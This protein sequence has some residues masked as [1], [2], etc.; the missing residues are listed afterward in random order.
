MSVM[1]CVDLDIWTM[2]AGFTFFSKHMY[3][4]NCART[5]I[6][7][8]TRYHSYVP[9]NCCEDYCCYYYRAGRCDCTAPY[10]VRELYSCAEEAPGSYTVLFVVAHICFPAAY[11]S[12]YLL[13]AN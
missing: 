13:A 9:V 3:T 2:L 8:R 6:C 5:C 7:A 12:K 4:C 10:C 11:I 1:M